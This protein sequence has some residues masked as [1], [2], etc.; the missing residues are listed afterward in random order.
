MADDTPRHLM[1]VG[2]EVTDHEMYARYRAGMRPILAEY[3]GRFDYDFVVA[4]VLQSLDAPR[5]NRL[6]TL[7]FPDQES[8]KRLFADPRYLEVRKS[9]FEPSVASVHRIAEYERA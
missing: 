2:L 1:E 7:S 3:G 9:F 4:E 8:A 5:I 6:F